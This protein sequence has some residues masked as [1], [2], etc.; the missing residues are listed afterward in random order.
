PIA[1]AAALSA[2]ALLHAAD[3]LVL[4]RFS[5]YL[6]SLRQQAGIPGLAATIVSVGDVNWERAFGLADVERNVAARPDTPFHTRG[7]TEAVTAAIALRCVEEGRLSLDETVGDGTVREILTYT[8]PGSGG[9]VFSYRPERLD[10]LAPR[11]AQCAGTPSYN[12]AVADLLERTAMFDSV[13]GT[14]ILAH[15][16]SGTDPERV[17]AHQ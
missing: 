3:D 9:P 15:I 16:I 2:S 8:T 12:N 14:G 17:P 7:L 11:I 6:E 5:D 1:L 10:Q 13:P 4:S